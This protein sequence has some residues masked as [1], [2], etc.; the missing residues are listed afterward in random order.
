[1]TMTFLCYTVFSEWLVQACRAFVFW[2]R[3]FP[4][5]WELPPGN[6]LLVPFPFQNKTVVDHFLT[7]LNKGGPEKFP[8]C[9]CHHFLFQAVANPDIAARRKIKKHQKM[10]VKKR[11]MEFSRKAPKAKKLK[12][13]GKSARDLAIL[14]WPSLPPTAPPGGCC[15]TVQ[16]QQH[17]GHSIV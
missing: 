8:L 15:T 13:K 4:G 3:D 10:E 2:T 12:L 14:Q 11:K 16:T 6:S 1:M 5:S 17:S 9:N 7:L